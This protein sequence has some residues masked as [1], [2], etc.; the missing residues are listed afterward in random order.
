M[1]LSIITINRNNDAGL[2]RTIESVVSQSYT[3]FEYIIIDGASKDGSVE[4]IKEYSHKITYWVSEPDTGIYNAMNKGIDVATGSWINFMNAGDKYFNTNVISS[5][6]E[7]EK[8]HSFDVLYGNS[9][10]ERSDK[11]QI[12]Q[13][14][15]KPQTE[16]WKAPVFRH[17]TMFTK[18]AIHKKYPFNENINYKI[19]A[20][21]DF[22]Y[23]IHTMNFTFKFVDLYIL[24]FEE[25]GIS[26]NLFKNSIYNRM[27]VLSYTNELKYNIW[28]LVNILRCFGILCKQ[29]M[30]NHNS[31]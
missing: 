18:T 13:P 27:V 23:K 26:N 8:N 11:T 10:L 20:D 31:N 1:K 3:D 22:I 2:R 29:K 7:D 5:I 14:V 16:L 17:G 6:F 30:F 12:K 21:F 4:V 24:I 28:H 9:I 15:L 19:C 25:E